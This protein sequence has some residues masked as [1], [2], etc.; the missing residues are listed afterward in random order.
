LTSAN[1]QAESTSGRPSRQSNDVRAPQPF[2]TLGGLD[3]P[4]VE[5][6]SHYVPLTL[7]TTSARGRFDNSQATP[8]VLT[9]T[10]HNDDI[11]TCLTSKASPR[12][13]G[14]PNAFCSSGAA[15]IGSLGAAAKWRRRY[16][17]SRQPV[18]SGSPARHSPT[19]P[20]VSG[21]IVG[22]TL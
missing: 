11:V 22:R 3:H 21:D 12:P 17:G 13:D 4:P 14:T 1:K 19:G 9:Y 20:D 18:D 2:A 16:G 7:G 8:L 6:A 5:A 15:T 10:G